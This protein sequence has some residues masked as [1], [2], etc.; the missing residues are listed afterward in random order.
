MGGGRGLVRKEVASAGMLWFCVVVLVVLL[1]RQVRLGCS[2][3]P[4]CDIYLMRGA[5][6]REENIGHR[7]V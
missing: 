3:L 2:S 7:P 6:H 5:T 4:V 1:Q